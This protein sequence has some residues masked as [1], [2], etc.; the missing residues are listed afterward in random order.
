MGR[1]RHRAS[2]QVAA[3]HPALV[4]IFPPP[5]RAFWQVVERMRAASIAPS[6]RE[7]YGKEHPIWTSAF[8]QHK[9][10]ASWCPPGFDTVR[11]IEADRVAY[12]EAAKR[13][14]HPLSEVVVSLPADLEAA[15]QV[16]C[17]KKDGICD[18]RAARM[19]AF[20]R[21]AAELEPW[22]SQVRSAAAPDVTAACG[23]AHVGMYLAAVV[24]F[25]WPHASF[26]RQQCVSGFKILGDVADTGLYRLRQPEEA[27]RKAFVPPGVML[28]TNVAWLGKLRRLMGARWKRAWRHGGEDMA[29]VVAAWEQSLQEVA[30]GTAE[31][32]LTEKEL[33]DRFGRGK[34]R[35]AASHCVRQK[36]KWRVCDDEKGNGMNASFRSPEAHVVPRADAPAAIARRFYAKAEAQGWVDRCVL[37]AS[38]D[39]EP[40]AYKHSPTN[41]QRYTVRAAIK[42]VEALL[43]EALLGSAE[44]APPVQIVYFI[45][46][47]H[48][49]GLE[50]AVLNYNCKPELVCAIG[51]RLF[52]AILEHF[53]DDYLSGPEP[54]FARGVRRQGP[55]HGLDAVL[56]SQ[57]MLWRML[58]V[59]GSPLA[60]PKS[61]PWAPIFTWIGVVTDC[62]RLV[63]H[64]ELRLRCKPSTVQRA[65]EMVGCALDEGA[66]SPAQA[67]SLRG[68]LLWVWL[69]GKIGRGEIAALADRQ[70]ARDVNEDQAQSARYPLTARL[71]SALGFVAGM[72]GGALPDIVLKA[73]RRDRKPTLVL[74]D[75]MWEGKGVPAGHGHMGFVLWVPLLTGGGKLAFAEAPA[76][77]RLLARL[78]LLQEKDTYVCQLEAVAMLAPYCCTT[79][80]VVESIRA[81]DVVHC[82]DNKG[83]N[84]AAV[85]GFSGAADLA[86]IVSFTRARWHAIDVDPWLE[87]VRSK[88]NIADDPSRRDLSL[89][90]AMGASRVSF[91]VPEGLLDA[92]EA[93]GQVAR[94]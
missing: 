86:V 37:G 91:D 54:L 11:A 73:A 22:S 55:S 40:D 71:H 35:A 28:A 20:E 36:G 43:T 85:K 49:F 75:A 92:L 15:V 29:K 81:T 89:L 52:A 72:L 66:L 74:T 5:P 13:L 61:V 63:S 4:G 26:P 18:W 3:R 67:G 82:A 51:R 1:K 58:L 31:G 69:Y 16:V 59:L 83:A 57:G 88:S 46:T 9:K 41:A 30:R 76:G 60:I 32:P 7:R 38:T 2:P 50:A 42:P 64:G 44:S 24:A 90:L 65:R 12:F 14:E 25:D 33:D 68:K 62:S 6:G 94:L 70:Y 17:E 34:W 56:S 45:P 8:S 93:R 19:A 10:H 53:F 87:Y 21:D 23:P 78:A 47:G 39:D 79:P 80:G 27:A 48:N 84:G 77:A